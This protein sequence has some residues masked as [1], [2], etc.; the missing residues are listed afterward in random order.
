MVEGDEGRKNLVSEAE[1]R[2][3]EDAGEVTK[4]AMSKYAEKRWLTMSPWTSS[5]RTVSA[6]STRHKSAGIRSES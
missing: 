1:R 2:R 3:R 5:A 6:A 4:N